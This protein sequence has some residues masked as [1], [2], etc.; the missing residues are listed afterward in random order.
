MAYVRKTKVLGIDGVKLTLDGKPFYFEGVSFF[1]AIF[2]PTF[3]AS[4]ENRLFWLRKFKSNGVNCVRIF[5]QWDRP[6]HRTNIDLAPGRSLFGDHGEV[7]EDYF[8]RLV[9][10][11]EAADSL[12]MVV[13]VSMFDQGGYPYCLPI[14]AQERATRELTEMLRPYGNLFEQIWSESSIEVMRY[15]EIAKKADPDRIMTNAPGHSGGANAAWDN[16]GE[17]AHNRAMDVLTPHTLRGGAFPFWYIAPA[18]MEY[19]LDTYQKPVIDDSPARQGPAAHGGLVGGTQPWQHIEQIRRDR[20]VGGYHIYLHGMHQYQYDNPA[21]PPSG[22]PDPDFN[23][24]DRQVFDY[25]R[26]HTTW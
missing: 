22:I 18:Q 25:L 16:T 8:Q 4:P 20:A 10:L 24:F 11:L 14:P 2:N 13:Q 3:N 26:D 6:P 17:D 7:R 1:N 15:L 19:L 23:A 21:T 12:D 9:A 5:C